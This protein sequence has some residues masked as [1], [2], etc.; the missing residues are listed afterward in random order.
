MT[1]SAMVFWSRLRVHMGSVLS[2]AATETKFRKVRSGCLEEFL[3]AEGVTLVG[4][5]LDSLKSETR[6][7][8]MSSAVKRAD[9]K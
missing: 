1:L 5:S 9:I 7:L 4:E 6:S 3:Y 2:I 8:E